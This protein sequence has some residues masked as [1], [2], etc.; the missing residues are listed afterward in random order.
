M[1]KLFKAV[2]CATLVVTA[3]GVA[4]AGFGK[5]KDAIKYRQSAM[6]LIGATFKQIAGVVQGKVPYNQEAF[7]RDATIIHM[8]S[9]MPWEAMLTPGTDKGDTAMSPLVFQ[10]TDRFKATAQTFEKETAQ[11]SKLANAGDFKAAKAQFGVVAGT[12][13]NCHS[14][15][16]KP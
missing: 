5:P 3:L 15:F 8:L 10:E 13:K 14:H 12:C 1:K 11:L 7:A 2:L 9:T 6:T 4:Q 16:R